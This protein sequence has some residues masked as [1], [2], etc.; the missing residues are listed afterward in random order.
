MGKKF[1]FSWSWRRASGLSGLK[2]K[3]ARATGIPLTRSGRQRKI[4]RMMGGC[5]VSV[6]VAA[7]GLALS[8]MMCFLGCQDSPSR[9]ELEIQAAHARAQEQARQQG[10]QKR[11]QERT[12]QGPVGARFLGV[13]KPMA[14]LFV[15][16]DGV[17]NRIEPQ[18]ITGSTC[19]DVVTNPDQ[20]DGRLEIQTEMLPPPGQENVSLADCDVRYLCVLRNRQGNALWRGS[21]STR[22]PIRNMPGYYKP[23]GISPD[24]AEAGLL[25]DLSQAACR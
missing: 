14:A 5:M 22:V 4:G 12:L 19:F 3:V 17:P 11:R 15:S 25:A 9:E 18:V 23:Q 20:A 21:R 6:V 2:G 7:L 13:K 16:V 8:I 10:E 1:G 24:Q